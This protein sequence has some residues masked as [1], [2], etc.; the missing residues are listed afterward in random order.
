V[1][2]VQQLRVRAGDHERSLCRKRF[3][4]HKRTKCNNG[5]GNAIKTRLL[6]DG[7]TRRNLLS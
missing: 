3:P 5:A 7:N 2:L 1:R 6:P 4:A